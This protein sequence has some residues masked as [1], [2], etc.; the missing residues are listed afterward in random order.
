MPPRR[1]LPPSSH[2]RDIFESKPITHAR[3]GPSRVRVLQS[4]PAQSHARSRRAFIRLKTQR[5][6]SSFATHL[7]I[8]AHAVFKRR[9]RR[10]RS[11][12]VAR[13]IPSRCGRR[14]A[15]RPAGFPIS[16]AAFGRRN[17]TVVCIAAAG[18]DEDD[19]T[20]VPHVVVGRCALPRYAFLLRLVS[21]RRLVYMYKQ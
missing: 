16:T 2:D 9:E 10:R 17:P 20:F 15:L 19:A 4:H 21:S 18:V 7:W 8:R 3:F 5:E 11:R 1:L 14:L 13:G 12:H 6:T